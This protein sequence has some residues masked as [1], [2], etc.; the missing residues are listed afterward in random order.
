[1]SIIMHQKNM[2]KRT[3]F[4]YNGNTRIKIGA[5]PIQI[6]RQRPHKDDKWTGKWQSRGP[7]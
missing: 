2:P 6:Q 7:N 3:N 5:I 1:M 4:L